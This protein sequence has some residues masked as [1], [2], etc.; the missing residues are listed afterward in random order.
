MRRWRR[1]LWRRVGSNVHMIPL[2]HDWV[3]IWE[4]GVYNV[5]IE[6]PNPAFFNSLAIY[7]KPFYHR[8]LT[9]RNIPGQYIPI[10]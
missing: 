3:W 6:F 10:Q 9:K 1:N 2:I 8:K 7:D 5:M 4:R